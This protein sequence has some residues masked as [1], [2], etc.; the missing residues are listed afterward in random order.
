MLEGLLGD[1]SVAEV[2]VLGRRAPAL[3]H[4]KLHPHIVDFGRLPALPHADEVYLAL[5]TTMRQAGSRAAFR[6]IDLDANLAVARA[7]FAAGAR[8]IGVVSAMGADSASPFFYNRVKGELEQALS[9]L[10]LSALVI[11]RPSLLLGERARL[12]QPGRFGE[13]AAARLGAWLRPVIPPNWRPIA[14]GRVAQALLTLVP[15]A[16][17]KHVLY[18]G[19]M[20]PR[21]GAAPRA[22]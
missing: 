14:A 10:A 16:V 12:G 22:S 4:P 3:A 20:Q 18:S 8:R 21:A 6:A 1:A 9:E 5:G 19:A 2:H 11:A 7:A 15:T 17:G 13:D